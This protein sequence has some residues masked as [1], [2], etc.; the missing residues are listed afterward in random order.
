MGI[1]QNRLEN[2]CQYTDDTVL[3][4]AAENESLAVGRNSTAQKWDSYP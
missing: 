2:I 3:I 1:T 4:I